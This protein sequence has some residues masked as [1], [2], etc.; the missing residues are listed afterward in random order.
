MQITKIFGVITLILLVFTFTLT[1]CGE[2]VSIVGTWVGTDPVGDAIQFV[3]NEDG[4]YEQ[5]YPDYP[6][7]LFYGEYETD[8]DELIMSSGTFTFKISGNKLT[9]TNLITDA[10]F[11]LTKSSSSGRSSDDDKSSNF[12]LSGWNGTYYSSWNEIYLEISVDDGEMYY[13]F[14]DEEMDFLMNG[15]FYEISG[16]KVG[17]E[18]YSFTLDEDGDVIITV[19]ND[20]YEDFDGVYIRR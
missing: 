20:E 10:V 2:E 1:G 19:Y 9:L 18:D 13:R 16:N 6:G 12:D 17:D 14:S 7:M 15:F 3:F 11:E 5:T 4:T 8:G